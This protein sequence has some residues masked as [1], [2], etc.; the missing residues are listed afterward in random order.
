MNHKFPVVEAILGMELELAFLVLGQPSPRVPLSPP[1]ACDT[2]VPISIGYVS[3]FFGRIT[4]VDSRSKKSKFCKVTLG[5][6]DTSIS[7]EYRILG[8]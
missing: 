4:P 6:S 2:L 8:C 7:S 3:A 5:R 1:F